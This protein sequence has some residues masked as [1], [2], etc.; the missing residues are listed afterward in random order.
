MA[1]QEVTVQTPEVREDPANARRKVAVVGAGPAGLSCAYFLA[2]LGYCPRVFEAE[3]EPGGMLIQAIPAY[4][5]PREEL[6]REIRMIERMGVEIETGRRLG[7]DFTLSSLR[8]DGYEAVFLGVGAP[9]GVSLRIPGDRTPGVVEAIDYLREYNVRGA[10]Q[11]GRHVVVIGG[12]NAAVDA[13][14]TALR[15]GAESVT[16]LYRRSREE[17]PA[18][19]EEVHEAEA[20]GVRI[21]TL[22]APAEILSADGRVSGVRCHR[23]W[24]GEFD[25]SGRRRP[26]ARDGDTFVVQADLVIAAIGQSLPAA[27]IA[28]GLDLKLNPRGFIAADPL[29][30]QTS[31]EWVFAGG[32]AV[33]GPA[34]VVDAIGA[35]ER[36]AV[37]MDAF[38]SGASHAFWRKEDRVDTFFD[39]EADPVGYARARTRLVPVGKRVRNFSEVEMPFG[40][41]VALREAK[42]CLRCDYREQD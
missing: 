14:R 17:M 23:M 32:D 3:S 38:L 30:G 24:L 42:R 6:W 29:T 28:A 33:L 22:V 15:L 31:V 11:P 36:A 10:A 19:A 12:G 4:R 40:E 5:L 25:R 16:I 21:E 8:Q 35:G 37:G 41:A 27:Q 13:S 9:A 20:E 1:E 39:P 18:Y 26:E 7:R 2:R 34:S